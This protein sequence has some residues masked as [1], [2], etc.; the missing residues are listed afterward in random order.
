MKLSETESD[1]PRQ[2]SSNPYQL[3]LN[4]PNMTLSLTRDLVVQTRPRSVSYLHNYQAESRYLQFSFQVIM[5][6]HTGWLHGTV[7][8][9]QSLNGELSLSC[10]RPAANG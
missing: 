6:T 2:N 9:R 4:P 8:E 10:A 1:Y 7:V 3:T 5:Q